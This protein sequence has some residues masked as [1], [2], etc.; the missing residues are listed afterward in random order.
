[1]NNQES[2][3]CRYT[4]P[5]N[6]SVGDYPNKQNC[7]WREATK[8]SDRCIWHANSEE[9][10]KTAEKLIEDISESCDQSENNFDDRVFDGAILRDSELSDKISFR[11]SSLRGADFSNADLINTNFSKADLTQ[12]NLCNTDLIGA[13]F[14]D[15]NLEDT[16][17][18]E[19]CIAGADFT[20]AYLYRANLSETKLFTMQ[21]KDMEFDH[22]SE[23]PCF[24]DAC[25]Q[26]ADL[27]NAHLPKTK[28]SGA[29]LTNATLSGTNFVGGDLTGVNL[30]NADCFGMR[31]RNS[32]LPNAKIGGV[33]LSG[34]NLHGADLTG[35]ELFPGEFSITDDEIQHGV[36]LGSDPS[37]IEDTAFHAIL[38]HANLNN[39]NLS[40]S[41][42]PRTDFSS[43]NLRNAELNDA[44]F[45]E[46]TFDAANLEG[47]N[48][49]N[50]D[51]SKSS[52]TAT[53]CEDVDFIN[54]VLVRASL[55]NADLVDTN[56]TGAYLYNT[57]ID[58][59]RINDN[60]QLID[61]GNIGEVTL[62]SR[63]RYDTDVHPQEAFETLSLDKTA[64]EEADNSPKVIQLRRARSTY[65]RLEELARQNGLLELQSTMFKRRQEMRRKL[66]K[67]K[68][69]ST[70]WIFAE[71]Q[72]TLF[73]YGESFKRIV[74]I[75]IGVIVF[76]WFM[77]LTTGIVETTGGEAI[78]PDT[79]RENPALM[80]D[81]LYHSISVFF[82]GSEPLNTT[83][84][85]GQVVI[86]V[87]RMVGPIFLALLVFVLGR[88]AAR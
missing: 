26:E 36:M 43:A 51:L 71:I 3:R 69:E 16:D 27:S 81:T 31:L 75:S 20:D 41:D 55:E 79:V 38:S 37:Q 2:E 52:L 60:T 59:A 88:R 12:A 25:L 57:G 15:T 11:N 35:A 23:K 40:E 82:T 29:T 80:W 56:L 64:L 24:D 45:S 28:L 61:E 32:N 58:G 77:F 34:A 47:S 83:G 19:A 5:E 18:H 7:C 1:M 84:R 14:I 85:W 10:D 65:R 4:Y 66:L 30:I 74:G 48:I 9:I 39:S 63:C 8:G 73:V 6:H 67:T 13:E 44:N 17:L 78:I 46:A 87:E 86:A 50:S 54:T 22:S 33:N 72:R 76:F 62:E 21:H 70:R 68:G 49:S 53:N 42:L